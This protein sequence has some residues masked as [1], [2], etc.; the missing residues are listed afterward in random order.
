[1]GGGGG[2]GGGSGDGGTLTEGVGGQ[3]GFPDGNLAWE[4]IKHNEKSQR[5]SLQS[6][7]LRE[8][9]IRGFSANARASQELAWN[10]FPPLGC[11]IC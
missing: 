6:N 9:N 5:C 3:T 2:E 4:A 11:V 10:D 1:M 7:C 8:K